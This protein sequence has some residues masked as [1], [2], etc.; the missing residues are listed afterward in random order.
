MPKINFI[1]HSDFDR[2]LITETLPYETPIIFSNEGLYNRIKN[3][4]S[5]SE[6]EQ[7]LIKSLV[8]GD[9]PSL[10]YHST[11]PYLYKIRKNALEYRRLALL[12]PLSQWKLRI[13]YEDYNKLILYFCNISPA[14]IRAPKAVASSFFSKSSWE[15]I[16][17]YKTASLTSEAIDGWTKHTP[18]FFS[19][20][21]YDRLYKFFKSNDY[22]SLE[23][24]YQVQMTLDVSK[25]FDSIYT[26]SIAWATKDKEFIKSYIKHKCSSFGDDFDAVIRHGNDN[27][28]NGIPIGPEVSR[29]FSEIIFQKIDQ[30]VIKNLSKIGLNFNTDYVFRRYV[31]D[32]YIFG[33]DEVIP[34]FLIESESRKTKAL[35][36]V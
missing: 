35:I 33:K 19:Y 10:P 22:F 28:T 26:H 11:K 7:K 8:F 21:G 20:I 17:K 16:Y 13:F 24:K 18:S 32:V 27:E 30:Q 12:H 15:N 34:P 25:C 6:F 4:E 23:K 14:S 31:D 29:L 3:F 9:N 1:K 2:V 5:S 36:I